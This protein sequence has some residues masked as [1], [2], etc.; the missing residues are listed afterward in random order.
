MNANPEVMRYYPSSASC[1]ESAGFIDWASG[2]IAERGWGLWAVE[3]EE[4][5][6]AVSD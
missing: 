1:E 6:C 4:G 2:L 3:G 5:A